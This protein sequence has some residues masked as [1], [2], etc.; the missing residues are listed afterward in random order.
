LKILGIETA[1]I[2]CGA[3]FVADGRVLAEH[4]VME[5]NVHAESILRLIDAVL[6]QSQMHF[7]DIDAVAVS[8]GPGS[9]TGLRIG[10]SAAKGLAYSADKP[11]VAV[12]TLLALAQRAVDTGTVT[13]PFI[14]AALDARRDEV[15]C[16]L[17]RVH[18]G[19]IRAEWKEGDTTLAKLLAELAGRSVTVTGDAIAKIKSLDSQ[20]SF[21]FVDETLARCS[22]AVVARLG[23]QFAEQGNFADIGK[24]E[25][26][27]IK[28]F[29]TRISN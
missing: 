24:I 9:F 17:F 14:L 26:T 15:Y 2:V 1:T 6:K 21:K 22:A 23:G 4:Q 13:T 12:P 28:D 27:Y 25:P 11:L 18:G 19:S 7:A 10:L 3:A 8:I 29:Y 5:R 16:Q 20:C